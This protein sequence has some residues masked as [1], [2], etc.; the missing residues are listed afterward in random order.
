MLG[1][2]CL[3]GSLA[4]ISK[5]PD[6]LS[7]EEDI[8]EGRIL[9]PPEELLSWAKTHVSGLSETE[10]GAKQLKHIDS[11]VLKRLRLYRERV[12]RSMRSR[13]APRTWEHA[14]TLFL[15]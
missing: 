9:T 1:D 7:R 12:E 14:D 10:A 6:L 11:N 13:E 3:R 4:A 2:L 8:A 15:P 5:T